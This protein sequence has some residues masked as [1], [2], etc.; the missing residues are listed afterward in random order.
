MEKVLDKIGAYLAPDD[1]VLIVCE[2]G[3]ARLTS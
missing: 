3:F 1:S 2:I